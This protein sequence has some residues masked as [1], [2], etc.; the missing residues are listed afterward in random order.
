MPQQT[1]EDPTMNGSLDANAPFVTGIRPEI[2]IRMPL[3]GAGTAGT[4]PELGKLTTACRF[5]ETLAAAAIGAP[6]AATA[7]T[8]NT[9]TLATPFAA[10]AQLYRGM[11]ISL[12]G[13]PVAGA[14]SLITDYT[15][16]RVARLPQDFS[17]ASPSP[18][19]PRWCRTRSTRPPRTCPS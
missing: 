3:R 16:G 17:P 12:T 19:W 13:N 10:T 18:P 5:V 9:A 14:I 8:A 4:A 2:T 15:V 7:G 1:A 11:P 6:T